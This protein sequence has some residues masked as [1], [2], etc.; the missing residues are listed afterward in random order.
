MLTN[1]APAHI[2]DQAKAL[3]S[4]LAMARHTYRRVADLI[5]FN[6]MADL[7]GGIWAHLR[8]GRAHADLSA[9]EQ[10]IMGLLLADIEAEEQALLAFYGEARRLGY[11]DDMAEA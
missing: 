10:R 9:D 5:G 11:Y 1:N 6:V 3:E 4:N 2:R 8:D 7:D